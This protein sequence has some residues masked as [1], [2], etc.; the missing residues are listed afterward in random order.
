ME[1]S[2]DKPAL[3]DTVDEGSSVR[4]V[5][6]LNDVGTLDELVAVVPRAD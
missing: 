1:S 6:F 2:F 5:P 3:M 4:W